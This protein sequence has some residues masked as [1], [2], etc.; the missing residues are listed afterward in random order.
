MPHVACVLAKCCASNCLTLFGHVLTAFPC[1]HWNQLPCSQ[2][3]LSKLSPAAVLQ[4]QVDAV[5]MGM[6]ARL[7]PMA[8]ST[9]QPFIQLKLVSTAAG[10]PENGSNMTAT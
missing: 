4:Q 5:I 7:P 3:R 8:G 9:F 6:L 1:Q 10:I 2:G